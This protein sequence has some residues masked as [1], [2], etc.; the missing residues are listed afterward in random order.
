[1]HSTGRPSLEFAKLTLGKIGIWVIISALFAVFIR[2]AKVQFLFLAAVIPLVMISALSFRAHSG[3][4][5]AIICLYP[6][7]AL[8]AIT[9][10]QLKIWLGKPIALGALCLVAVSLFYNSSSTARRPWNEVAQYVRERYQPGEKIY[11]RTPKI[12]KFY[13]GDLETDV[14]IP[15][16]KLAKNKNGLWVIVR[17]QDYKKVAK[18][19]ILSQAKLQKKY[20]L[21]KSRKKPKE[22]SI[23]YLRRIIFF[24]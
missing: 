14:M 16:N 6:W 23:F 18:H 19:P 12:G 11:F 4:R 2:G 24:V 21:R 5:Y 10:N 15:T 9:I 7:F 22:V 20:V 13:L 3:P 17:E 8:A 1:M